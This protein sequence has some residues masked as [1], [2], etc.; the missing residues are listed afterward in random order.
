MCNS[1]ISKQIFVA[2]G[3][4][5]RRE[6]DNPYYIY[7][8]LSHDLV[9]KNS[10]SLVS[11]VNR[12]I[13]KSINSGIK[14][15]FRKISKQYFCCTETYDRMRGRSTFI[16]FNLMFMC[17]KNSGSHVSQSRQAHLKIYHF[18]IECSF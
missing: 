14:C 10:A 3:Y 7:C 4:V 15:S 18:G 11:Q 1:N 9:S 8:S 2:P 12:L 13:W 6:E 5:M 16:A 17:L